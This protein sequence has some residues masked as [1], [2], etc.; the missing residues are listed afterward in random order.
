MYTTS[1][2]I[3]TYCDSPLLT[4][5][6]KLAIIGAVYGRVF[7]RSLEIVACLERRTVEV[8]VQG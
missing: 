6:E 7:H 5:W 2:I 4:V 3:G 8:A 1:C